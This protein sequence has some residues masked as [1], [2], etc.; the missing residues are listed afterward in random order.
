[1]IPFW[2]LFGSVRCFLVQGSVLLKETN[3]MPFVVSIKISL[4]SDSD[5]T[6][7]Y[8]F[9]EIILGPLTLFQYRFGVAAFQFPGCN[10][11]VFLL[12]VFT[13]PGPIFIGRTCTSNP[14][15]VEVGGVEPV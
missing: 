1:M 15:V 13:L 14:F 12:D 9:F 7:T 5:L 8:L 6:K 3:E 11:A 4:F 10:L 2:L